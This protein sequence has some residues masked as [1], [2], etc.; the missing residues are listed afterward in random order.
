ML[1]REK[2]ALCIIWP[3][4]RKMS[5][6]GPRGILLKLQL[7]SCRLKYR[8][9]GEQSINQQGWQSGESARLQ[10][11]WYRFDYRTVPRVG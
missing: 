7:R 8:E 9:Q 2:S 4:R 11:M 5:I 1:R 10:P 6:V 3:L